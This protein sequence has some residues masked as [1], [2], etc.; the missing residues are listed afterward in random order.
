[1][2]STPLPATFVSSDKLL[3]VTPALLDTHSYIALRNGMIVG[4][5]SV[6]VDVSIHG[7]FLHLPLTNMPYVVEAVIPV[8]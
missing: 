3:A 5:K 7:D 8:R 4:S 6:P 1:M 2:H